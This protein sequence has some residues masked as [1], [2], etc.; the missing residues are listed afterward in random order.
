MQ[1]QQELKD[2]DGKG[3]LIIADCA[4]NLFRNKHF[5]QCNLVEKWWQDIYIKWRH[6]QEKEQNHITVICPYL[7]SLLSRHPFD[8]HKHHISHNHSIAIDMT[9]CILTGYPTVKGEEIEVAESAVSSIDLSTRV[10][11]AEPEP[12]LQQIYNIWLHSMGFKE[13]V[14]TDSGKECL[15]E[16]PTIIAVNK[17]VNKNKNKTQEFDMIIL[18]THLKDIPYV[19]VAKEIVNRTLDQR[20]IFTTTLPS[21]RVRQDI[22][23]MGIKNN[24]NEILT[25]PFRF[26]KLLSLICRSIK[27]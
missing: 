14:I 26:S 25:K 6:R 16:I 12:D 21:D 3:V 24:K 13:V 1:L 9:G 27:S 4:D 5:D 22:D 15:D 18:D 8:Q 11:V 10:L 2:R 20:I 19:Q 17:S 23:S 7:G